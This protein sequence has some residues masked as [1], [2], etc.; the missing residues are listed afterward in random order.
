MFIV[1]ELTTGMNFT[2][3]KEE[4]TH[5]TEKL[6]VDLSTYLNIDTILHISKWYH[7]VGKKSSNLV[8]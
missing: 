1:I 8:S 2:Q 3:L 6:T 7:A 5:H 4:K